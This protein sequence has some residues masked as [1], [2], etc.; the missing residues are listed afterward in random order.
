MRAG[1]VTAARLALGVAAGAALAASVAVMAPNAASADTPATCSTLQSVLDSASAGDVITL[2]GLCSGTTFTLPAFAITLQ[3]APGTTSGFDGTGLSGATALL[4]GTVNDSATE[5]ISSLVFQ[6]NT[7][8]QAPIFGAGLSLMVTGL[9]GVTLAHDTFTGDEA[10]GGSLAYGGGL[11][12]GDN[13]SYAGTLVTP[14]AFTITGSTFA[15]DGATSTTSGGTAS[16]GGAA[17]IVNSLHDLNVNPR[18]VTLS[19][20]TFAANTVETATVDAGVP[21]VGAGLFVDTDG[22]GASP[23]TQSDDAFTANTIT[24]TAAPLAQYGGGGEWTQG[25]NVTSTG[26]AF[27]S[28]TIPGSN[29]T[30][31]PSW[32]AGLGILNN[33]C[34]TPGFQTQSTAVDLIAAANTIEGG[35]AAQS[36]GAGIYVGCGGVAPG[37]QLTLINS[38]VTAN[39]A[40]ASGIAGIAGGNTDTLNLE[41]T[42]DTANG[43]GA[44]LGGFAVLTGDHS[45][46]CVSGAALPGP[47]NL[48]VAP[49]LAGGTNV[50]ETAA[51]PTIDAGSNLLVP[52]GLTSSPPGTRST[53]APPRSRAAPGS[54]SDAAGSP[55]ATS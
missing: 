2:D 35:T 25:F 46:A 38:T 7:V 42:I 24:A 36:G 22:V 5:T 39:S 29:G 15:G 51:S 37:N 12:L 49:A 45:D 20:D 52:P 44:D 47:G 17:V 9:G 6:N 48:C 14:G 1:A 34:Q 50:A 18:P 53:A 32:G 16:G 27:T 31:Q 21:Q 4:R 3:G 30:G 40:T 10:A 43:G 13:D 8:D 28:N 55:P 41:N 26:D 33:N 54:T 11:Y 19:G 23:L